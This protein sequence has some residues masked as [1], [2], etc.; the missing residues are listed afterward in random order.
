MEE[1][2]NDRKK[3]KGFQPQKGIFTLI[4]TKNPYQITRKELYEFA[5]KEMKYKITEEDLTIFSRAQSEIGIRKAF[6][7]FKR[8][9]EE[10]KDIL[11]RG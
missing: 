1:A 10:R 7:T 5:D 3:V 2:K 4:K 9:I 6:S 8:L 11:E